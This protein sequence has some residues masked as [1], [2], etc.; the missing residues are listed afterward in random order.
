MRV[1]LLQ[2]QPFQTVIGG[3]EARVALRRADVCAQ[4]QPDHRVG[5][6]LRFGG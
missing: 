1:E 4:M 5:C 6:Q 3:A 2:R